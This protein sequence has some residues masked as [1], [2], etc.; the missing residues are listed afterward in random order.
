MRNTLQQLTK[1]DSSLTDQLRLKS[2]N[3]PWWRLAVI[4]AH[5]GD[6]WFWAG[7]MG[8]VWLFGSPYWRSFAVVLGISIVIQALFVFAIKQIFRR[9]RPIGEWG[10]F[11]RQYDPHSFPSGH[12]TRA[13]LLAVMTVGLGP[14]WLGLLLSIWAPLVCLSRVLTGM[15][16]ISDILGG[17]LLGLFMGLLMV[18]VSPIW[19]QL[20][21]FLF[22]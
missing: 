8:V 21:P 20:F 16:F 11:Y 13:V 1:F 22:F 17:M 10:T 19:P 4:V 3:S 5:S 15:H 7:G 12:A 2:S 18:A 6:S 9:K 14:A